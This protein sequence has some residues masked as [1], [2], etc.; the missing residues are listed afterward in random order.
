MLFRSEQKR[1][2]EARDLYKKCLTHTG[3]EEKEKQSL[4][5]GKSL[6]QANRFDEAISMLKEAEANTPSNRLALLEYSVEL[7]MHSTALPLL[8]EM[9]LTGE[10][11]A[12][13]HFLLSKAS[14]PEKKIENALA[15][16]QKAFLQEPRNDA[17]ARHL[18]EILLSLGMEEKA[19]YYLLK[20]EDAIP[21]PAS[22]HAMIEIGRASCRERV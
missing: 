12:R 15:H 7:G 1:F 5:I 3:K 2:P 9:A 11:S 20:Y 21:S 8:E 18:F 19:V 17:H 6:V 22:F 16:A 10:E 14:W 4:T 13:F